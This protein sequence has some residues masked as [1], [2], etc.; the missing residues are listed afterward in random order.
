MESVHSWLTVLAK[1]CSL[2][3]NTLHIDANKLCTIKHGFCTSVNCW[4]KKRAKNGQK[5]GFFNREL[6]PYLL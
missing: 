3:V 2:T 6:T 5:T 1:K 4:L